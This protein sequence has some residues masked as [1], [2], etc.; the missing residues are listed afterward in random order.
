M[1]I[2]NNCENNRWIDCSQVNQS[3]FWMM[4]LYFFFYAVAVFVGLQ[5]VLEFMGKTYYKNTFIVLLIWQTIILIEIS[6][7][8][9]Y[10]ISTILSFGYVGYRIFY[11]KS[12]TDSWNETL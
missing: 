2:I 1:N 7:P 4:F 6:A 3:L 8:F 12:L 11:K 10:F 9:V 5:I